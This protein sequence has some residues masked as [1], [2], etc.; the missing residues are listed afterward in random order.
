MRSLRQKGVLTG[1]TFHHFDGLGTVK[2][3][4]PIKLKKGSRETGFHEDPPEPVFHGIFS[5]MPRIYTQ[6]FPFLI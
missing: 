1:I 4:L 3:Q 2:G 6:V 5:L